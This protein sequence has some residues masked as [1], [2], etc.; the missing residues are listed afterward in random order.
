MN[1]V[2]NIVKC[3]SNPDYGEGL[4]TLYSV[5]HGAFI[6]YN[7]KNIRYHKCDLT[8]VEF[9]REATENDIKIYGTPR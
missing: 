9:V 1:I 8:D 2:G 4:C 7:N 6:C 3:I 5:E